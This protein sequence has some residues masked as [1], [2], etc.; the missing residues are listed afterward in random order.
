MSGV[1][2]CVFWVQ[3]A[4][5]LSRFQDL[6]A[7]EGEIFNSFPPCSCTTSSY[8]HL[9]CAYVCLHS[10][11]Y[12]YTKFFF[13]FRFSFYSH[14]RRTVWLNLRVDQVSVPV[15]QTSI[16]HFPFPSAAVNFCSI[17]DHSSRHGMF[18]SSSPLFPS[19]FFH[20][21]NT[22]QRWLGLNYPRWKIKLLS[23]EGC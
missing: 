16:S 8:I 5:C 10:S 1:A 14:V 23:G 2:R 13:V 15:S 11:L 22:H 4:R 20:Y 19:T 18:Y 3:W 9:L 7:T 21:Q 6:K 12:Y 17:I